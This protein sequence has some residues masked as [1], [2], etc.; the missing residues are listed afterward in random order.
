MSVY[1][2]LLF[3][4][5]GCSADSSTLLTWLEGGAT[6]PP[7]IGTS[8][9][10]QSSPSATISAIKEPTFISFASSETYKRLIIIFKLY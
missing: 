2:I 3:P 9:L 6:F 1:I 10:F 8:T 7:A 4:P 5:E